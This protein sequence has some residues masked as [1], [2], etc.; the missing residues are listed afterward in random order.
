MTIHKVPRPPRRGARSPS[1]RAA[2][3]PTPG[4]DLLGEP[5]AAVRDATS[6]VLSAVDALAELVAALNVPRAAVDPQTRAFEVID[7]G[8]LTV[9]P[10][11]LSPLGSSPRLVRESGVSPA[12]LQESTDRVAA[13]D[14]LHQQVQAAEEDVAQSL[15]VVAQAQRQG[16]QQVLQQARVLLGGAELTAAQRQELAVDLGRIERIQRVY[17]QRRAAEA[18]RTTSEKAQAAAAL[19]AEE[20]RLEALL[21]VRKVRRG[22]PV[23][24]A[25]LRSA[26]AELGAQEG[27][28]R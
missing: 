26:L 20:R 17:N 11:L 23:D 3:R 1:G 16:R 15:Q 5:S 28:D 10:S 7:P 22:E 21:T 9:A 18:A 6:E 25:A 2:G 24:P 8:A 13:M 27:E 14:A 4:E 19:A 12:S